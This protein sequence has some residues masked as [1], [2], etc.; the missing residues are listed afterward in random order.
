M[1][2]TILKLVSV[3]SSLS[4]AA[5]ILLI[6]FSAGNAHDAHLEK[7]FL[8]Y[9]GDHNY[10]PFEFIDKNGAPAGFNIDLIN[11]IAKET[12]HKINIILG[13]W[14][15][16]TKELDSGRKELK[17]TALA[18]FVLALLSVAVFFWSWSLKKR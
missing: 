10:P 11:A 17:Y 2:E 1:R 14:S 18:L 15:A 3:L 8:I 16:M 4:S 6:F 7:P 12:D 9:G 5:L 13:P